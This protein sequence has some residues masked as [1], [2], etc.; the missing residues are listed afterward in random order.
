[1]S[2]NKYY[3]YRFLNENKEVIYVGKAKNIDSRI[4]SH[5]HLPKECYSETKRI[6]YINCLSENESIIYEVY[7]ISMYSPKY[8]T[9]HNKHSKF[10]FKLPCKIWNILDCNDF[11]Y[12]KNEII[13]KS[14]YISTNRLE[15]FIDRAY[16]LKVTNYNSEDNPQFKS[17]KEMVSQP[18]E[19]KY[20]PII[21]DVK[22]KCHRLYYNG[23]CGFIRTYNDDYKFY[24]KIIIDEDLL[25]REID[26]KKIYESSIKNDLFKKINEPKLK[27][28]ELSSE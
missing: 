14:F 5:K 20:I 7:L 4:K 6:E 18:I 15:Y 9:Q 22:N 27:E 19:L 21:Y 13:K 16:C 11:E 8:N 24:R 26:Y 25:K 1:M 12:I 3:V 23:T 17:W 10:S 2:E 28:S